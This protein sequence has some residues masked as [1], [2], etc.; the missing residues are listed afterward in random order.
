MGWVS[1]AS[2]EHGID[3]QGDGTM[4]LAAAAITFVSSL[5]GVPLAAFALRQGRK[6]AIIANSVCFAVCW[7]LKLV[8]CCWWIF[9]GRVVAGIGSAGAYAIPPLAA[10]E[11]CEKRVQGA[12]SAALVLAHNVGILIMYIVADLGLP[13]RDVL[14]WCLGLSVAHCCLFMLM[15]ESPAYL[16]AHNRTADAINTL[17]WLR[18]LPKGH[19]SIQAELSTLP[20]PEAAEESE[21][22]IFKEMVNKP[23]QR[24]ALII[25]LV[26]IV[27]QES[28]G[29]YTLMQFAERAFI[30][31]RDMAGSNM[32][33]TA[34]VN[35]TIYVVWT[36]DTTIGEEILPARHAL[37]LGVVQLVASL[38][39][40]FLVELVGRRLLLLCGG[41]MTAVCLVVASVAT[42]L[43]APRAAALALAGAVAADS[44]ALEPA[45]YALLHD[46][47]P[48]K[49]RSM[50]LML[51]S[52]GTCV[53]G[54]LEV[55]VLGALGSYCLPA[56][57]LLA[58]ALSAA[59]T[60][61][62]WW[63]VPETLGRS[64]DEIYN[65]LVPEEAV[66]RPV[67]PEAETKTETTTVT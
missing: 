36:T 34:T 5:A 47:F 40:L 26:T 54:A 53:T 35:G 13:H 63:A 20:V 65:E 30:I 49:Y 31:T 4:V 51:A 50:V 25:S 67:S 62:S 28:C 27:G 11:A 41:T 44:G 1:L 32:A 56:A 43:G 16:A 38:G 18:G 59:I 46:L 21:W 19:P 33:T 61:Y 3:G 10:S 24:R 14:W 29:V 15:P 57:L 12:A 58:A 7:A 52:A 37:I 8:G 2:G 17:A 42:A 60:L 66:T 45:P 23:A 22:Q 55:L 48:Y 64:L 39:A 9:A 6:L